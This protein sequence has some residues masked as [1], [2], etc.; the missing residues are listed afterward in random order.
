MA[1]ILSG[2]PDSAVIPQ[3]AAYMFTATASDPDLPAQT[4][5]YS[6]DEA[7]LA[8]AMTIDASTGVFSW[9]PSESQGGEDFDVTVTVTDTGSP[10]LS[11]SVTLTIVVLGP[12]WQNPRHPCD[13]TDD[14]N[15]S[16]LDVLS[17]INEINS[18]GS[19]DLKALSPPTPAPPPFLDPSG[20]YYLSALDVLIVFN[21]LRTHDS[22]PIPETSLASES[23]NEGERVGE[24]EAGFASLAAAQDA[25]LMAVFAG[26]PVVDHEMVVHSAGQPERCRARASA[27][28]GDQQ[29]ARELDQ[30]FLQTSEDAH[31][32]FRV[33]MNR[34][35]DGKDLGLASW[36]D[37][38]EDALAVIAWDVTTQRRCRSAK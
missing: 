13:I 20:D 29:R 27:L 14:R 1:P 15:I 31:K 12:T 7:S 37:E 21:H 11:K 23:S 6:L 22:G 17:L 18:K 4:L 24:G 32:R 33:T 2:V 34:R 26:Q 3:L 35:T 38:T 5:T 30:V 36:W 25:A 19:R 28:N 9:T 16:P 10:P 8:A